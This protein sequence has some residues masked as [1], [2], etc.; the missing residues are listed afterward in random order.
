MQEPLTP[1]KLA[2]ADG[3]PFSETYG[4]VYHSAD[5]GPGQA[6]HVFLGG[7]DLPARWADPVRRAELVRGARRAGCRT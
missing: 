1:A 3:T 7:N 5:S 4:D 2:F 6:A